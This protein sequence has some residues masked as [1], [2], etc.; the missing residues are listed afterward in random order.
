[1]EGAVEGG[2][3]DSEDSEDS[4]GSEG[5]EGQRRRGGRVLGTLYS[6]HVESCVEVVNTQ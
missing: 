5:S 2:S 3:E 1:M 6:S 4:E